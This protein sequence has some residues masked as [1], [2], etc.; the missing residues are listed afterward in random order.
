MRIIY[1]TGN[2]AK[3]L[4][5]RRALAD[6]NIEVVGIKDLLSEIPSVIETGNTPLENA[7]IKAVAYYKLLHEPVFSCDSGLY[8]DNLPDFL[9]PG[10]HVRNVNGKHMT[11]N[12]MI[13][14]Y[15]GLAHKYGNLKGRYR[16]AICFVYDENH[17]YESFADNLSSGY[18][19][20]VEKPHI[21]RVQ[22]FPLDSLSVDISSRKYYYD[23]EA[24]QVDDIAFNNGFCEFFE[25]AFDKISRIVWE[26]INTSQLRV[27]KMHTVKVK[28]ILSSKNGMNLYR[29][30]S[31]GCIYCDSRSKC[32]QMQHD[33]EDIEVKGNAIELLEDTLKRKWKPCMIG[34]GAMTDPYIPLEIQLQHTRQCLQQQLSI[35]DS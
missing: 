31:H 9:Q 12:E 10:I 4:S 21:K 8:I 28:G 6:L 20:L 23:I 25:D 1:G 7:R 3:L 14:Y 13:T 11:D 26:H 19:L 30:C 29:G 34:T 35:F 22:G 17:I 24:Y 5:M 33:F 18:F 15:G 16:N 2:Q 32:Y 27:V